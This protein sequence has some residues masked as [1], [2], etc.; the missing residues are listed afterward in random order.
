MEDIRKL[1]LSLIP[2]QAKSFGD[3]FQHLWYQTSD[4][5]REG[6]W[7][8]DLSP[9]EHDRVRA[10]LGLARERHAGGEVEAAWFYLVRA[11]QTVAHREGLMPDQLSTRSSK[12]RCSAREFTKARIRGESWRGG[13]QDARAVWSCLSVAIGSW[14]SG[15]ATR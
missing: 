13:S 8:V 11:Q 7:G 5:A 15:R 4:E 2:D 14:D 3:V 1:L 12:V 9:D 6:P 10:L